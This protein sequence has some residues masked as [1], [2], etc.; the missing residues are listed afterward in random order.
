ME[1]GDWTRFPDTSLLINDAQVLEVPTA[2][3]RS[4]FFWLAQP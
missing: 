1:D 2:G 3:T 4:G